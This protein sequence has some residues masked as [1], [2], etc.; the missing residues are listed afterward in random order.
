MFFDKDMHLVRTQV[1]SA[2]LYNLASAL[3]MNMVDV[4][5]SK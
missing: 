3:E 2:A 1:F 5:Y 4:F